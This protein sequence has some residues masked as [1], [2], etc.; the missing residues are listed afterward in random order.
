[1]EHSEY[2]KGQ[3]DERDLPADPIQGLAD[4][5]VHAQEAGLPEPTAMCVATASLDAQ[6]SA[7][8]VLLRGIDDKGLAF[9]TN[10]A[11]RKGEELDDNPRIAAA[12]WWPGLERQVRV[13]GSVERVSLEESDAY[14]EERP[15]ESRLASAASPQSREVESRAELVGLV[16]ELRQRHPEGPPR[17]AGWG[18][19][20]IVPDRIE[21]WQGRPARLHDRFLYERTAEGWRVVRLAP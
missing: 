7:R 4:W 13:E 11:S 6:P 18:G 5:L 10:Y 16:E 9:F 20:R 21:F 3:L 14:F 12:F 17:P 15:L 8:F 19:Y 1:M 2:R